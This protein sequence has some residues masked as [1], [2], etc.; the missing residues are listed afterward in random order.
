MSKPLKQGRPP[1]SKEGSR[2]N[3]F[4]VTFND[5]EKHRLEKV[6]KRQQLTIPQ[7]LRLQAQKAK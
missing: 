6:V 2:R 7:W 1:E 5:P 3:R 4:V